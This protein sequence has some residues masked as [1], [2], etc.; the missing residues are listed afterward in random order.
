MKKTIKFSKLFGVMVLVSSALI[1]S[2][3]VGLFT[4]GINF[5]I[6]FQAGFIEKVRFA[7]SAF[8]LTYNGEKNIQVAQSSQSIDV[9][10]ISTD[11]ENRVYSFRYGEYPTVGQ[12]IEAL[13]QQID[14]IKVNLLAKADT[15]LQ[16]VFITSEISRVTAEPFRVHYIPEQIQP[17]DADEVRHALASIPSVSVQQI[18]EARDRTFQIRLPDNGTYTNAN[19]ELRAL[20][21]TALVNAYEAD[22]FA[23]LSTDFVGSRFS[24][25]L[26]RQAVLLVV[27]A[28]F[29]IFFY[30][31]VRF[32]W[33]FALGAVLALVHDVL[34]ML[35]FI[36][37]T[38]MEFN[39]TTIAAILT[40]VGYSINDTVVVFDRIRE[41]IRLN[42]KL[43]LIEVVY[44]AQTE[45]L[46]RTI[47]TTVTTM[48]AAV[49]LYIFTTGTMK[50]FAL[51]LLVG[52]TSGVYS[53]IYIAGACITFFSGKKQAGD[54]LLGKEEKKAHLSE[55]TV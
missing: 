19:A 53:T 37:W 29:L 40:I 31:L 54:L 3:L 32:R 11:S 2:G 41:N 1:I 16:S 25:S 26:A 44:L 45:V 42:P 55:V 33:T 9:T 14:G 36:V 10:V 22:N 38:Q 12:F 47:I 35:T 15:A 8:I 46:S 28:L 52:M 5:G 4:K 18:G 51:A 20:I 39:S 23:V 24:G 49:S 30:A 43:S 48:L 6:D 27:G 50:D 13:Q 17:I 21:N 34:I 7:P